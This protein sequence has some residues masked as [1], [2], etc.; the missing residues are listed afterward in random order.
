MYSIILGFL[1]DKPS[2]MDTANVSIDNP[3]AI[4]ITSQ[5][6]IRKTIKTIMNYEL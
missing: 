4:K 1:T 3:T 2:V 6:R 5:K